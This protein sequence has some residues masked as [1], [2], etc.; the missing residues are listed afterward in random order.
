VIETNDAAA[1]CER[2][3]W[4]SDFFGYKIA[5]YRKPRCLR[6]DAAALRAECAAHRIDCAY[7]L[8][9]AD[10]TRS[11]DVLQRELRA[12]FADA[13]IT[14]AGSVEDTRLASGSW[15]D[16][17]RPANDADIP[18]LIEIASVSHR[19]TRFYADRHFDPGLCNHLY[20]V[21]IEKSCRGFADAVF[22]AVGPHGKPSG[23]VTCHRDDA[24]R[25]H[26][27]LIAVAESSQ[28]SGFGKA[29]LASA[30]A[31]FATRG[32][33]EMNVATQLRNVRALQFYGSSGLQIRSVRFWF[34]WWSAEALAKGEPRLDGRQT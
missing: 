17:V 8:V 7:V 28:G 32:I 33:D 9:D 27:G 14:F 2:L 31:W 4:D 10:D 13:R 24:T 11:I 29:L 20:E 23:Y 30:S 6:G 5:R 25:G 15:A 19:D 12:Y 21:W 16:T 3:E 26:I 1:V 34:H 18:A 22:V